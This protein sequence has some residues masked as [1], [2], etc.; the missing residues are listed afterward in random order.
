MQVDQGATY[1]ARTPH[2]YVN[3]WLQWHF[4]PSAFSPDFMGLKFLKIEG[5][6]TKL[7]DVFGHSQDMI[8]CG[9]LSQAKSQP[10]ELLAPL[11]H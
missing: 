2:Q 8:V 3:I 5:F 4:D 7:V 1:M 6:N 11:S 10:L 9:I